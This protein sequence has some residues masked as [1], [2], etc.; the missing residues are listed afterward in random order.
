[1]AALF[2][3]GRGWIDPRHVPALSDWEGAISFPLVA[4]CV[5]LLSKRNGERIRALSSQ[6]HDLGTLLAMS[7]MMD[8][9]A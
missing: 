2:L 5:S 7:Q 6:A 1:M 8:T 3:A 9:S 4:I